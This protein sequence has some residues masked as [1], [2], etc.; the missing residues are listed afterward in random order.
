M[1]ISL[2]LHGADIAPLHCA[3]RVQVAFCNLLAKN[4]QRAFV[5]MQQCREKD[6]TKQDGN[7]EELPLKERNF[8]ERV[9]F[10]CNFLV[11]CTKR[12]LTCKV[13][14]IE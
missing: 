1:D 6:A 8:L 5:V 11:R 4:F 13:L 9:D 12:E 3:H 2:V 7:T 10:C 14:T